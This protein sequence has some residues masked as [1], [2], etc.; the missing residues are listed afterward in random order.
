MATF[1]VITR[2]RQIMSDPSIITG[3]DAVT[4]AEANISLAATKATA[5]RKVGSTIKSGAPVVNMAGDT[6]TQISAT[7][8]KHTDQDA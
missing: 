4:A 5:Q 6:L 3:E 1:T 8:G 7:A 2:V